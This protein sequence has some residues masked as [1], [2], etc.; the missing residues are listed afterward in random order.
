VVT[1][2]DRPGHRRRI[3]PPAVKVAAQ[4]LGL[5]VFQPERIRD[6]ESVD[7]VRALRPEAIILVAYGQIIPPAI[8]ELAPRG[9]LN[10]HFSLLPRWRGA[11]PV[12][13]AILAGDRQTG[14]T[15]MQMDELLDHGPTL[16]SAS[17]SIGEREDAPALSRR[18]AA[19]GAELLTET[20]A[21]IDQL[22]P[23]QQ[24]HAAATKAGKLARE[25]GNLSWEL[26]AVEID[27]TVR[28]FQ[29][30]P[31][32][33]LALQGKLLKV[34]RGQAGTGIGKP[35]TILQV[36][37]GG[38]EVACGRGSYL[39]EEVQLPGGRPSPARSVIT[40]GD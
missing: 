37:A 39:L 34:N 29:P 10:V 1:Q 3:T 22:R 6:P 24:D 23:Q 35:G 38:V 26:D 25:D 16:A 33:V 40:S 12:A 27:R 32:V 9:I 11:A 19:I 13:H 4:E 14:V 36:S 18:L 8:L 20:L 28:A 30:W 31:G 5:G 21:S 15:I 17:T 7:R 2:P